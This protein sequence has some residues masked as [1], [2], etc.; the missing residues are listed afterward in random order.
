MDLDQLRILLAVIDRGSLLDAAS[1]LGLSRTTLRARLDALERELG[2]TLLLR[3]HR[4]VSVTEDGLY[5]AERARALLREASALADFAAERGRPPE[6]KLN[7]KAAQGL[8]PEL[9]TLFLTEFRRRYP[10]VALHVSFVGDPAAELDADVDVAVHFGPT[11]PAGPFRTFVL[12]HFTERLLASRGY[13]AARGRP[14][15]LGDLKEHTLLSW[16]PP[17]EDGLHWPLVA[18]GA[19]AVAPVFV[20]PDVH[21]VRT[22]VALGQG[23]ALLP[24]SPLAAGVPGEDLEPVLEGLV[25]R[26]SALRVLVSEASA[27]TGK[28]RVVLELLR[29]L[30]QVEEQRAGA[31][32]RAGP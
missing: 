21:L 25:G 20:C 17:A 30:A 12:A 1:A 13:L 18:G 6:G 4:G 5:F 27:R 24:D 23:I 26:E 22:L 2:V 31:P 7:V 16:R 29:E 9:L 19:L 11:R 3:T 28:A 15:T 10:A 14:C 8:P 32:E